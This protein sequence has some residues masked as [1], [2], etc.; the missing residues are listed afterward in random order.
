VTGEPLAYVTDEN[1]AKSLGE[2]V[3]NQQFYNMQRV[4]LLK[5]GKPA[6][7]NAPFVYVAN[8]HLY[9]STTCAKKN[10]FRV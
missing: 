4:L 1:W 6:D 9:T 3:A 5:P 8:A 7:N 10:P 2:Y